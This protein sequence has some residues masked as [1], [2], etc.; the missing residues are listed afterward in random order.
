M[1]GTLEKIIKGIKKVGKKAIAPI[2]IPMMLTGPINASIGRLD[3]EININS[4]DYVNNTFKTGNYPGSLEGLDD[5]DR[6]YGP[7]FNPFPIVS[8]VVSIVDP[9]ELQSDWRPENSLSYRNLELSLHSESGAPIYVNSSNNYLEFVIDPTSRGWDFGNKPI[10][11]QQQDLSDLNKDGYIDFCDFAILANDHGKTGNALAGDISGPDSVSDG[12]V[13]FYDLAYFSKGWLNKRVYPL[14]DVRR[15]LDRNEGDIPLDDLNG[16]Y[17]SEKPSANFKLRFDR[18]LADLNDDGV[19][20]NRDYNTLANDF[21]KS[22][23]GLVGDISG[24]NGIPDGYVDNHDLSAFCDDYLKSLWI[25]LGCWWPKHL[26]SGDFWLF[27][28]F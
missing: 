18:F 15:A 4:I 17:I 5:N 19:V 10:T 23:S 28:C 20:D 26:V 11:L 7:L 25:S 1:K 3:I 13:D 16:I 27:F 9:N 21:G 24:V 6:I 14:Y 22:E 8:K 12:K 2:L